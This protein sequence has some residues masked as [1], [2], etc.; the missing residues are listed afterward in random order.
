MGFVDVHSHV[1][2]SGDDG[3]G[4]LREALELAA[5]AAAHGTGILFATPH[6]WPQLPLTIAREGEVRRAFERARREQGLPLELRLG[7]ELTPSRALLGEDLRRYELEGTGAVLMEVPFSGPADILVRLA[8]HAES[9][10]LQPV[11][12]HPERTQ[13][14]QDRPALADEL[15]ERRWLL[16]VNATSLTG[17]HGP[18][19]DELGWRLVRSGTA[20]LVAS[21][22]HRPTRPPHLDAAYAEAIRKVG[23]E[24]ARMLFCGAA[25]GFSERAPFLADRPAA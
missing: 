23:A 8:E 6:V 21:D 24:R 22:G 1:I 12:A 10:G 7:F 11:I 5:S 13:A 4:T 17:D 3:A 15:A 2:P 16:Q 20:S 18:D 14:V 9:F 25:L 19:A